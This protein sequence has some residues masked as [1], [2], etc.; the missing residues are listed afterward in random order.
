MASY[1]LK[2]HIPTGSQ[3]KPTEQLSDEVTAQLQHYLELCANLRIDFYDC[4][5]HARIEYDKNRRH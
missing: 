3:Q 4:L 5:A 1:Q 2:S